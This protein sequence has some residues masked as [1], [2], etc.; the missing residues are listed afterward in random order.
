MEIRFCKCCCGAQNKWARALGHET[1]VGGGATKQAS[2]LAPRVEHAGLHCSDLASLLL[3]GW[4]PKSSGCSFNPSVMS[5][6]HNDATVIF[7]ASLITE[8]SCLRLSLGFAL[9]LGCKTT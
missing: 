7:P 4:L 5:L 8:C 3:P 6:L 2:S 1:R 9:P